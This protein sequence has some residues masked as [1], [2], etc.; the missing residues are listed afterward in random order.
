M[1]GGRERQERGRQPGKEG[2]REGGKAEERERGEEQKAGMF[3][4]LRDGG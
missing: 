3:F 1:G 4:Y 2:E